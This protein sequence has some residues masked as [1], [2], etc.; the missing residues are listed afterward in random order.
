MSYR[1][2]LYQIKV[3]FKFNEPT[4]RH[5]PNKQSKFLPY[6][7]KFDDNKMKDFSM[8]LGE[9]FRLLEKKRASDNIIFDEILE[10]MIS[11]VNFDKDSDKE[12]FISIV[13]SS[14]KTEDNQTF[15]FHPYIYLYLT[16]D[17]ESRKI[18]K[19]LFDV[20]LSDMDRTDGSLKMNFDASDVLSQLFVQVL[21]ES[22]LS[23]DQDNENQTY[24][25]AIPGI[26]RWFR[27]DLKWLL[28]NQNMFIQHA[29]KLLK[30]YYFFYVS[31]FALSCQRF[32]IDGEHEIQPIYFNLEWE[33]I[34]G[35]RISY[36][37]GW[38]KIEGPITQLF[39]H[40]NCLEFLNHK[41]HSNRVYFYREINEKLKSLD[42]KERAE[43]ISDLE[44]LIEEYQERL[45]D[46]KWDAFNYKD[47]YDD[48]VKNM[49][50]KLFKAIDYQFNDVNSRKKQYKL[51]QQ[52]FASFCQNNF[53]KIRG[54]LG[55]TLKLTPEYLLFI[56][57]MII[58][59]ES[60]IRLKK[61]FEG[62]SDRG[63]LFDRDS[64]NQIIK[65]FEVI[66]IIE[67]KSD[68]G[69]AIYV[70]SFL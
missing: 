53:I 9:F 45:S 70:K 67:K 50:Y 19:F 34:S 26:A 31:Q 15:I 5:N 23:E 49:M 1:L 40:V 48:Q 25:C 6:T 65:Y 8:I 51:Y 52:W 63:I 24:H 28:N 61:L 39:S 35:N 29:E 11:K 4:F 68:S 58:K 41:V 56:T 18:G 16:T 38:K 33:N 17:T 64:Q 37:N 43:L 60:K 42:T 2:D 13:K 7:S 27:D 55:K 32:L 21:T 69:D 14:F 12:S 44:S 30:Y 20:L 46:A 36:E 47:I 66:N 10:K 3:N 54:R 59:D 62:F 22:E 57:K